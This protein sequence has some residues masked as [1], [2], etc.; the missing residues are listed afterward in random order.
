MLLKAGYLGGKYLL[1]GAVRGD[2]TIRIAEIDPTTGIPTEKSSIATVG[3]FASI[4]LGTVEG[5][6]FVFVAQNT[7][8][9]R[10]Y[11]YANGALQ[12]PFVLP[13]NFNEVVVR[14][15]SLPIMFLNSVVS[16]SG[17]GETY[18]EAWDTNWITR[19]NGNAGAAR[20]GAHIRHIGAP[21][22]FLG[23]YDARARRQHRL[24]LPD[25]AV[26]RRHGDRSCRRRRWISPR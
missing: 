12:A 3:S 6:T 1:A 11:E 17:A 26:R 5:R 23:A 16:L 20:R 8:G 10:V 4:A 25:H 14:G 13:G 9:L 2:K 18:V 24:H 7:N 19:G 21:E 22:K 15:G